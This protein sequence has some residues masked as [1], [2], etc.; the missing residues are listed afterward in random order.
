MGGDELLD[1]WDDTGDMVDVEITPQKKDP[2]KITPNKAEGNSDSSEDRVTIKPQKSGLTITP[3]KAEGTDKDEVT[4]KPQK[5]EVTESKGE[6]PVKITPH[7]A[8]GTHSDSSEDKDWDFN[9]NFNWDVINDRDDGEEATKI[10]L[11]KAE[12]EEEPDPHPDWAL[13]INDLKLNVIHDDE[14][15]IQV[16]LKP[17]KE[18]GNSTQSNG[19]SRSKHSSRSKNSSRSKGSKAKEEDDILQLNSAG[20]NE[21][22]YHETW[23]AYYEAVQPGLKSDADAED[24]PKDGPPR[25]MSDGF[26]HIAPHEDVPG[27]Q[28]PRGQT[29]PRSDSPENKDEETSFSREQEVQLKPFS[30]ALLDVNYPR[31]LKNSGRKRTMSANVA[32]YLLSYFRREA[33]HL[34]EPSGFDLD[35]TTSTQEVGPESRLVLRCTGA[36]RFVASA[37]RPLPGKKDVH[38]AIVSATQGLGREA[39]LEVMYGKESQRQAQL[40]RRHEKLAT[41]KRR[42]EAKKKREEAK[43]R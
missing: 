22:L 29:G 25:V 4:I 7:K 8:Q 15:A 37:P 18:E 13:N 43:K 28:Q 33:T 26:M 34:R 38:R 9:L 27:K 36:A 30:V 16:P 31:S 40:Q 10:K 11:N 35:C 32:G 41:R 3:H 6:D 17:D 19:S 5:S 14:K 23:A 24:G 20:L 42:E 1:G 12:L 21:E 2:V 39:F